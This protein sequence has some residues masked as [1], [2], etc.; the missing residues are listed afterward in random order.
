MVAAAAAEEE[1]VESIERQFYLISRRIWC[2]RQRERGR[3]SG[4]QTSIWTLVVFFFSD[5][6]SLEYQVPLLSL[7]SCPQEI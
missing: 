6:V 5:G 4:T 7:P 1:E 2:H 3:E